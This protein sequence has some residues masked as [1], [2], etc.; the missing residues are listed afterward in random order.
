[1]AMDSATLYKLVILYML[2]RVDFPLTNAQISGFFLEKEYTDYFKV[3]QCINE[4]MDAEMLCEEKTGSTTYYH[5][6]ATG[7]ETLEY[8][9]N[10]IPGPMVDDADVFLM[11]N[12]YELRNEVGTVSDCYR[13]LT[14]EY[15]VHCQVKEGESTLIE[16]KLAVP[17]R[18]EAEAMCARWKE[19]SQE[20]YQDV[21]SK[22]AR[23]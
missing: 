23:S 8:F 21:I 15:M 10:R 22:L 6:T 1:M 7:Q 9:G 11:K 3:Q 20:I 16:L 18:E 14:G 19:T 17:G 2:K 13:T 5:I 4:L 12:K